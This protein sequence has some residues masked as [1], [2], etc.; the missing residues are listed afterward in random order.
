MKLKVW[1]I[2]IFLII[3][4]ILMTKMYESLDAEKIMV[5]QSPFSGK[6]T[7]YVTPGT[8]WQG[9][10]KVTTYPRRDVYAY[11]VQVRFYEGGH[12][13]MNGSIQYEMPLDVEKL[14]VLH[15]GFGSP[16]AIKKQLVETVTI[17][18]AYMSG[19]LMTSKE[20]YAEKRNDLIRY[21]EDQVSGGVYRTISKE[22]KIKD[23]LT[24]VDKTVTM[25][26]IVM[27]NGLP[28][29]QEDPTL[30]PYGIRPFNF[31]ITSLPYDPQVEA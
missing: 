29:R 27:K 12:G 9:F 28:E 31:T 11:S 26:E 4:L 20:S 15:K 6:L 7:W 14:T 5:V 13:V 25:V 24:G 10:G 1:G 18:S 30:T 23:P 8:K 19:P 16:E 22:T 2:S 21:V 17:K 3:G